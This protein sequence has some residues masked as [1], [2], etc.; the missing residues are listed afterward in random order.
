MNEAPCQIRSNEPNGKNKSPALAII[1]AFIPSLL[2]A[3]TVMPFQRDDVP[4]SVLIIE[5]IFSLICCF[6]S[7]FLLLKRKT[8]WA[9]A[10]ALVFVLLNGLISFFF[11][12]FAALYGD[13]F[14]N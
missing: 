13:D 11:G 12:F 14:R 9:I 7:A 10:L 3:G 6:T 5:S 1:L 4:K 8:V 2:L